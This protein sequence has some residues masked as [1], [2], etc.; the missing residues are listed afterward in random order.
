[1]VLC[2]KSLAEN[3]GCLRVHAL[4]I[5]FFTF[6][7]IKLFSIIKSHLPSAHSYADDTQLYL[8]FRPLESTGEAEALDAME[9]CITDVRS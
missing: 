3:V 7:A 1:M 9:R 5:C 2:P 4:V 8:S 6:Y